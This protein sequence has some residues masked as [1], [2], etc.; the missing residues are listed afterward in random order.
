MCCANQEIVE[1]QNG[2]LVSLSRQRLTLS[3]MIPAGRA[4]GVGL[5][6]VLVSFEIWYLLSVRTPCDIFLRKSPPPLSQGR[7]RSQRSND[8]SRDSIF[9][10][11]PSP[12]F[13]VVGAPIRRMSPLV[14]FLPPLVLRCQLT[15][16]N[17]YHPALAKAQWWLSERHLELPPIPNIDR[18]CILIPTL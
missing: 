13:F 16:A 4:T 18:A 8:Y 10:V 14:C 7:T 2:F 9:S 5:R 11:L 17:S 15:H 12:P 6:F 3:G 1:S